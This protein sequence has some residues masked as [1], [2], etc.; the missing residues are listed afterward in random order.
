MH[1]LQAPSSPTPHTLAATCLLQAVLPSQD[2][3]CL[4]GHP[5]RR[6]RL[7][8]EAVLHAGSEGRVSRKGLMTAGCF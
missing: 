2:S 8:A 6:L 1:A 4:R 5:P 7:G 3:T